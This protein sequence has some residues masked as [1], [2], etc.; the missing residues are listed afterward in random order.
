MERS[1]GSPG[2]KI[3]DMF[4]R[5]FEIFKLKSL[6]RQLR[7]PGGS[8]GGRVGQMMNRANKPL[9]DFTLRVMAPAYYQSILEIGFGNGKFF[10]ELAGLAE[11]LELTGIDYSPT[12]VN[13]AKK[14][15][16]SLTRSGKLKLVLANSEQ[17]PFP[18]DSFDK[19]FCINVAYFWDD[20]ALHLKEVW[21]VLKPGGQLYVTVRSV[22][23]MDRMPF[24]KY[25]FHKYDTESWKQVIKNAGFEWVGIE[26]FTEPASD[27]Q[28][29]PR[30]FESLCYISRKPL[31]QS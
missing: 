27:Y 3:N 25:G 20:P 2:A 22:E 8:V 24:T 26:T 1:P 30:P 17:M 12:M 23:S 21:R 28:P 16:E 15:N 7:K 11:G 18:G 29:D 14:S 9:Y 31:T 13:A 10:T 6:A 4:R 19:A 5:F